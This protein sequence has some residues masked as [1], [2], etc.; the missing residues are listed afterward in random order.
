MI[1]SY[2][3]HW[4]VVLDRWPLFLAGAWIDI[5]VTV[6]GFILACLIG[7]AVALMRI[8]GNPVLVIPAIAF[9]GLARGVPTYV[10]LL[11]V[12]FGIAGL[13]GV[14]FTPIESIVAV[15]AI[16]GGG[17]T[18]EIFRAGL[19]AVD[20]GQFDAASSLGLR[21]LRVYTDVILPQA[22]R[23]VVPPLGNIL[24]GLLKGATLMSVIAVPDMMHL[25]QDLN[26]NHFIPFEAFTA[27]LLVFV[28]VV[29]LI[30]LF[31]LALE[32]ALAHP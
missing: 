21:K 12:H 3:F 27:V 30:A 29:S 8:G 32:R 7:L 13:L 2:D 20:L 31:I 1:P 28:G 19:S 9:V 26:M 14:A 25:A 6:V 23:I 24:V 18:A 17:Y 4:A 5:W 22:L 16:T 11:W 15:L 10:F